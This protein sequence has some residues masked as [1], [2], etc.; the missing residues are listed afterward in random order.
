MLAP[1]FFTAC[2]VEK[3]CSRDSTEQ[4]PAM[5]TTA[6]SPIFTPPTSIT[7]RCGLT[8]R[9]T[10]L[11]GWAICTTSSTPG[12]TRRASISWRRPLPTAAT[13]VRVVPRV[14]CGWYP[15]SRTRS[16]IWL[17]CSSV[18]ASD[19]LTIIGSG[20]PVRISPKNKKPRLQ[21]SRPLTVSFLNLSRLS[22]P[23]YPKAPSAPLLA[24]TSSC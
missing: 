20:P 1:A 15:A 16:M 17:I 19:M 24:K 8:W 3:S 11:K 4:G 18:A 2:A 5:T 10:S 22:R 6:S 12:A 9:L 23:I 7:E 13:M 21:E 14:T